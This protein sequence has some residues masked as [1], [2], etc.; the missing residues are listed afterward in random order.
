MK[1]IIDFFT[2]KIAFL[3]YFLNNVEG[4]FYAHGEDELQMRKFVDLSEEDSSTYRI[5]P[6]LT[7]IMTGSW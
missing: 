2:S 6:C 3:I 1:L 5:K 7:W 4:C